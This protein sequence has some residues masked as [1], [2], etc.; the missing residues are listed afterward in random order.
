MKFSTYRYVAVRSVTTSK[1]QNP[2]SLNNKL[3]ME[4]Q[5]VHNLVLINSI[6][7]QLTDTNAI[8]L[9]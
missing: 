6:A 4:Q 3:L 9:L 8:D 7:L 5:L 1:S 2:N